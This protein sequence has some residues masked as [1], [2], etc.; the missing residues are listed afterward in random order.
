MLNNT[1]PASLCY[2]LNQDIL[3]NILFYIYRYFKQFLGKKKFEQ[4]FLLKQPLFILIERDGNFNVYRKYKGTRM[5]NYCNVKGV[6]FL[7]KNKAR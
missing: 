5:K 1:Y 2:T 7:D 3:F 4:Y 6:Y